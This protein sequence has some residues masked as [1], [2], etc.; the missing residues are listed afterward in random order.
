MLPNL[1]TRAKGKVYNRE[2]IAA[3]E[4]G[5]LLKILEIVTRASLL[6][7]ESRGA[8]YRKD[9]PQTDNKDW[10]KNIIATSKDGQLNL[11]TRDVMT[12]LITL[13]RREKT[14]YMI[15]DWKFEKRI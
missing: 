13:P 5:A 10:L 3:L 4:N 2:W 6:R 12:K 15:P 9:Y 11:E 1:A 7:T 14:D 8:T